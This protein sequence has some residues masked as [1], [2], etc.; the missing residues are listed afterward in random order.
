[1]KKLEWHTAKRKVNDLIPLEINPRKI[2]E[3]KKQK[4]IDS[5]ERF[6]LVDIPVIN[7]DNQVIGGHQRLKALQL[8]GRGDEI[9]DVR[10][11][12]RK[13]TSK[14]LKEYNIISNTHSGD[15]DFDIL[16]ME[17]SDVQLDDIG[18]DMNQI[19]LF[20][21][22]KEKKILS[23]LDDDDFEVNIEG[24][25]T[26]I[27]PGD[28]IEIG[29]HRLLCGSS[30]EIDNWDKLMNGERADLLVTDPP[31]NVNYEGKTKDSLK[32]KNDSMSN[33]N[34]YQF[35]L[36]FY[37]AVYTILK[38]GGGYIFGTQI[39]KERISDW[40]CQTLEYLLNNV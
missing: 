8:I 11:P 28:L 5:I 7:I 9:I 6:N 35:L 23:E 22:S 10:I 29:T 33:G 40:L 15:W 39:V 19:Q 30:T 36:D 17:F 20:N 21:K 4:L 12:N 2:T 14:E 38:P 37:S 32:I 16:E 27:I 26:E 18:F 31:Y 24:K 34:F 13:L 3:E 1:M 25:K